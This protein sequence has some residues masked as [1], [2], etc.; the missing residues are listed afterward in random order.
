MNCIYLTACFL[1]GLISFI[2]IVSDKFQDNL[3]QRIALIGIV[4]S[5]IGFISQELQNQEPD[6]VDIFV[7]SLASYAVATT[8]KLRHG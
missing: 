3:L 5:C 1:L 2:G 4:F 8:W 6:H 7:V